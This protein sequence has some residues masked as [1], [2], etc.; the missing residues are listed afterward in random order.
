[1]RV[2]ADRHDPG[3]S[4]AA[5]GT[6]VFLNGEYVKEAVTADEERGE[7]IVLARDERGRPVVAGGRLAHKT[8]HGKVTLDLSDALKRQLQR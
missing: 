1:M 5:I 3:Y 7:V 4:Q 6:K 8:L 2:S